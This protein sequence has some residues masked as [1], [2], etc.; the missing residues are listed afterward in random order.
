MDVVEDIIIKSAQMNRSYVSDR[1]RCRLGLLRR[2]VSQVKLS[3]IAV[4]QKVASEK[5]STIK[6]EKGFMFPSKIALVHEKKAYDRWHWD[7]RCGG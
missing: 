3:D 5:E 7:P 6:A 2:Y 1:Y 4:Q